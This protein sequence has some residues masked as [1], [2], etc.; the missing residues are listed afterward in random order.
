M[1]NSMPKTQSR[2]SLLAHSSASI[3]RMNSMA[4]ASVWTMFAVSFPCMGQ[5][6]GEGVVGQGATS[7]FTIPMPEELFK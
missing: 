1:G 2:H 6:M 7:Y 5:D 4:Q 3:R